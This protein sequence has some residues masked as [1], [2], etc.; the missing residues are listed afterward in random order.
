LCTEIHAWFKFLK[1]GLHVPAGN[2]GRLFNPARINC[3]N[4]GIKNSIR[5]AMA[6]LID[7]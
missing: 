3:V 2:R 5:L 4:N 1:A 7:A 6:G